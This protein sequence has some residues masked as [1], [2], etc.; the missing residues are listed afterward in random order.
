MKKPRVLIVDDEPMVRETLEGLLFR[1][2]YELYFASNGPEM[3]AQ[4]PT[5]LPDVI[6]LDVM[7]PGMT[8]FEVAKTVKATPE[9]RHIPVVLI[10][11]LDGTEAL[12]RG[13]DAGADEFLTKPVNSMELRIRVRSMLRIKQQYDDLER[14]LQLRE[15]LTNLI[16][17]DMRN[18]LATIMLY[19]QLLQRKNSLSPAQAKFLEQ[20][21]TEIQN[22]NA[23]VD[24]MLVLARTERGELILARTVCN[25]NQ[26]VSDLRQKYTQLTYSQGVKLQIVAPEQTAEMRLDVGLFQRVLDNLLANALKAA[27]ARSTIQLDFLQQVDATGTLK[28]SVT[29]SDEGA[30]ISVE[31]IERIFDKYQIVQMQETE[32]A[33]FGLGLAFC[34][35]VIEAHGGSIYAAQRLGGGTVVTIEL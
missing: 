25:I 7:M 29:V 6:L 2:G 4:L 27:P 10:T 30:S 28:L 23:Y 14:A 24:D 15:A 35:T 32:V 22:M 26:I 20:I 1:E 34:R 21:W 19:V 12:V 11:A 18:P 31:D 8:G 13:F 16:V 9:T 33:K 5:V 17:H 3:L